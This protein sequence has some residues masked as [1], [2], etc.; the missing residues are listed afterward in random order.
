MK[1]S[2]A[3]LAALLLLACGKTQE[4]ALAPVDF[5][6]DTVCVLDGMLLADFP[7][8]KAQIHYGDG[9]PDFFC[10]TVE[11]FAIYLRPEQQRPVRALFVQDMGAAD[12]NEPRGHWVDAKGAFYVRGSKRRGSMGPTLASFARAEDAAAFAAQYGGQV[13]RFDQITPDMVVLDGG[14]LR[15]RQMEDGR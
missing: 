8:P 7:G 1:K 2:I 4:T 10:D 14:V 9:K 6:R 3:A 13:L 15:D 12:W 5:T 11:M